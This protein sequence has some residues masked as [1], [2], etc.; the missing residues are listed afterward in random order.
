MRTVTVVLIPVRCTNQSHPGPTWLSQPADALG[1]NRQTRT[2]TLHTL[3]THIHAYARAGTLSTDATHAYTEEWGLDGKRGGH[4]ACKNTPLVGPSSTQCTQT[5]HPIHHTHNSMHGTVLV[6][7][8]VIYDSSST[9][10]GWVILFI[11]FILT[12]FV[13]HLDLIL[14]SSSSTMLASW[15]GTDTQL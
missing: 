3:H 5:S 7:Y 9:Y 10:L 2:D 13:L 8:R 4:Y 14:F 6:G 15:T 1:C 12:C 11:Y